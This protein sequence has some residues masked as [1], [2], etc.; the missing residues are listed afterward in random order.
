MSLERYLNLELT[1]WIGE[2]LHRYFEAKK[3]IRTRDIVLDLACGSGYGTN[4]LSQGTGAEIY[5]GDIQPDVINY[6]QKKWAGNPS[7]H[8]EVMDATALRF[9]AGFFDRIISLETIE[10]LTAYKEMVSEFCRVLKPGGVV[11]VSTPN[12][13]ISSPDGIVRDPY[14]TQEFTY[15]EL[16]GILKTAFSEVSIY[17]QRYTRYFCKQ[18]P[19]MKEMEK[20]LLARGV[21]KLPYKLRN[22]LFSKQFDYP[23]YPS[24]SDFDLFEIKKTV[25]KHCHV[26]FAVC[27]K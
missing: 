11:I 6:C 15:D 7:L 23:L 22:L 19:G 27:K 25:E 21:R 8:F 26:L 24:A 4:I 16:K 1:P 3:Y 17:G 2:H 20:L 5:G 18:A 9:S 13:R 10:H 12:I 14:H